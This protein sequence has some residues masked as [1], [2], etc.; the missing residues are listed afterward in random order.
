MEISSFHLDGPLEVEEHNVKPW[1]HLYV[2]PVLLLEFLALALTRAVLPH[3]LLERFQNKVYLVMGLT[4]CIRGLLA[5]LSCPLFGK[6]SDVVGRKICLF[7][8]VAGT[9]APVCSLVLLSWD[10]TSTETGHSQ[11]LH[12]NAITIFCILMAFSGIFSSTFTLVFAYISD[13][14]QKRDERVSAY[15]LALATFGLSFTIGPMAGGCTFLTYS[16]LH[17]CDMAL[18]LGSLQLSHSMDSHVT[19]FLIDLAQYNTRYVFVS[20]FFLTVLDLIY[21]YAILPE[22]LPSHNPS[23]TASI[24]SVSL[25][26]KVSWSPIATIRIVVMDPFLRRV[27]QV[28]FLYYTALW[29]VIS[30]LT[31]YAT[32]RFQLG[33]ERLGELMSLIGF[34]TMVAE[35][36]MV[37]IM[38]PMLGEKRATRL[39]LAAFGLQCAVLGLAYEGWHLFVC[40]LLSLL[41]NLVYPSLTSLVSSSVEPGAVG[42]A[43]GAVNGIKALTEGVGPLLF[44]SL[45]TLSEHSALPG[46]PYLVAALIVYMAYYYSQ[47]LPDDSDEYVHELERKKPQSPPKILNVFFGSASS[48]LTTRGTCLD[49]DDDDDEYKGLLGAQEDMLSEIEED[50]RVGDWSESPV[51]SA[52]MMGKP[53]LESPVRTPDR[54]ELFRTP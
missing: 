18:A 34:S 19:F 10:P 46:W 14:I 23:S 39:G 53:L 24:A 27:G 36:V 44:G 26:L 47:Y 20:S 11:T 28:A 13:T 41:G 17:I 54:V 12:P 43:L 37:R 16:R 3:L 15:G 8:T 33:P 52:S 29:A 30:T 51:T 31:L 21:I 50:E 45:M 38:V 32:K 2:L 40:I 35:A 1:Q 25:D 4:E 49:P 5:F 6:L 7:V 48:Q 22:S 42:E 9:C